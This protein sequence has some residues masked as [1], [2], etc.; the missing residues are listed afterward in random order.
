MKKFILAA[1][2]LTFAVPASALIP[3]DDKHVLTIRADFSPIGGGSD[4]SMIG[5]NNKLH[6]VARVRT[7]YLSENI[8]GVDRLHLN[9]ALAK[10]DP[11][12]G[13]FVHVGKYSWR[14]DDSL[15]EDFGIWI[16]GDENTTNPFFCGN[17]PG[18]Q[19]AKANFPS[20]YLAG[21]C[22]AVVHGFPNRSEYATYGPSSISFTVSSIPEPAIWMGML[23]GFCLIG[24]LMRL[25]GRRNAD[26]PNGAKLQ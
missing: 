6:I 20:F 3:L 18:S 14:L 17:V 7:N 26:C 10:S 12:N 23:T 15:S 1:M 21:D 16:S 5:A 13:I 2:A 11:R 25:N 9:G 19:L 8:P 4:Y 22:A 24:S